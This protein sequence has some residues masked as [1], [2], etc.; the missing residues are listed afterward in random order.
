MEKYR[1]YIGYMG[2]E[3][4][5]VIGD[6]CVHATLL[7]VDNEGKLRVKTIEGERLFSAAEVQKTR[8]L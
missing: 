2:E 3:A 1:S 7:S 4:T 8:V 6:E 5:L